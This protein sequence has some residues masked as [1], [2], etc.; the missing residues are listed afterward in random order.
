MH[1][2]RWGGGGNRAGFTILQI[3]PSCDRGNGVGRGASSG[4]GYDDVTHGVI[5]PAFSLPLILLHSL[6]S[7][8]A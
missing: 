3:M 4:E 5:S 8:L 6:L 7:N 1:W 2:W